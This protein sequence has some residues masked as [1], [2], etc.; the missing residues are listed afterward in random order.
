MMLVPCNSKHA[1][2]RF[3]PLHIFNRNHKESYCRTHCHCVL[4][5]VEATQGSEHFSTM[6][7]DCSCYMKCPLAA[8]RMTHN[9]IPEKLVVGHVDKNLPFVTFLSHINRVHHFKSCFLRAHFNLNFRC[10]I[11]SRLP[12]PGI[13]RNSPYSTRFQDKG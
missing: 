11:K 13:I 7:F 8:L 12:F 10:R 6:L 3:C 2:F 9:G 5:I 4:L 1:Q